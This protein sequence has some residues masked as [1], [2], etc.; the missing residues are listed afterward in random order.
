M[1]KLFP[2]IRRVRRPL[3]PVDEPAQLEPSVEKLPEPPRPNDRA[4]EQSPAED[5]DDA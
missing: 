1:D 4:E 3:L 5:R 2:I